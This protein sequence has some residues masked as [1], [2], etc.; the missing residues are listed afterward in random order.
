MLGER[1]DSWLRG[2]GSLVDALIALLLAASCVLFGLFVLAE[3]AYFLFSLLLSLPLALRRSHPAVCAALVLGAAGV[4]WLAIR[5]DVGALP[6]DLAVP[7][8]VHA[9]AAYGP[10]PAGGAALGAGLAGSVLGGLSWPMLPSSATAHLLVGAFLASTVVAAWATGTLRRVR[11]SHRAQEARLAVLA[12]RAR[13]AHEMHDIVAHSL[14]V[15][16]AQADGGRY[17]T[18]PEAGRSALVTIAECARQ[19]LSDLRRVLGVLRDG[20]A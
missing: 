4:Q 6:A 18:S 5:D 16:I 8:A 2:H 11:L 1:L 19:A 17:A 20:P 13:I 3:A 10:R 7:L 12:E 14:A 9:A 15:V